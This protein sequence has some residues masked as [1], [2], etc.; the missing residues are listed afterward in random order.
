MTVIV[1]Y[2]GGTNSVAL[3]LMMITK[4]EPP[5]YAIL[6][7]NTGDEKPHTYEY[8]LM[9]SE[10][11]QKHGYPLIQTLYRA[12]RDKT[13]RSLEQDCLRLQC[14]PSVAYGFKTCSQ[15]FKIEPQDKWM[16]NDPQCRATWASGNLVTKIIGYDFGEPQRASF[17]N[18]KKYHR[19]YPLIEW[20]LKRSDCEAI[21]TYVGLP[22]PGK[23]ACFYCPHTKKPE[24][25]DLANRY[26]DL[27]KRAL[28]ME[29]N[30]KN[31][32]KIK[33]LGRRFAWA[34]VLKDHNFEVPN[35]LF[36]EPPC[37][38]YDA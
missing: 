14:L 23:S 21:I 10:F 37:G 15:K 29:T 26:P 27:A 17:G 25:I 36:D 7:A 20:E 5:P 2:G 32:R 11:I 16:N 22:L 12:R 34:D 30:A 9:F 13:W 3:L 31:L 1:S 33:G 18:D 19:R 8:L 38:C 4:R 28:A 35:D 24:I 6:F